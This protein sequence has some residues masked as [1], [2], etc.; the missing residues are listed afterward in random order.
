MNG[1][2]CCC[3]TQKWAKFNRDKSADTQMTSSRHNAT[4]KCALRTPDQCAEI[5]AILMRHFWSFAKLVHFFF[6][7]LFSTI[8]RDMSAEIMHKF[9]FYVSS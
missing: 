9:N 1:W 4:H 2:C 3:F 8:S 6:F 7:F 5:Y